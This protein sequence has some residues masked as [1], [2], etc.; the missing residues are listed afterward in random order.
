[1]YSSVTSFLLYFRRYW[2]EMLKK[3]SRT[4]QLAHLLNSM[5]PSVY[6]YL[7]SHQE[8]VIRNSINIA[9]SKI[10]QAARLCCLTSQH[11]GSLSFD[12]IKFVLVLFMTL[13]LFN[14]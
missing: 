4:G 1:M 10:E 5:S 14:V 6:Y 2:G 11:G 13:K 3:L 9:K 7:S 12:P 8:Y